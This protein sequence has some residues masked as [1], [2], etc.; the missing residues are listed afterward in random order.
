MG[1]NPARLSDFPSDAL[2]FQAATSAETLL[3]NEK[4]ATYVRRLTEQAYQ[5]LAFRGGHVADVWK[6][7]IAA[8]T[9]LAYYGL[10]TGLGAPTPGEE[11]CDVS[12]A[13]TDVGTPLS[14]AQ[15]AATVT[16]RTLLPYCFEKLNTKLLLLLRQHEHPRAWLLQ[17]L[18]PKLSGIPAV[19]YDLHLVA[20]L[21]KGGSVSLSQRLTGVQQASYTPAYFADPALATRPNPSFSTIGLAYR[22]HFCAAGEAFAVRTTQASIRTLGNDAASTPR[23]RWPGFRAACPCSSSTCLSTCCG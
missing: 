19:I 21:L 22:V 6:R 2:R 9:A 16:L 14:A 8:A 23:V 10:T 7:E 13:R 3:A 20:F 15:R 1:T 17:E 18:L 12:P 4:D 11:Y 5:A